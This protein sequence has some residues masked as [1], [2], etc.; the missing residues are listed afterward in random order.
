MSNFVNKAN[1]TD[2]D[3]ARARHETGM[4]RVRERI[5]QIV[6]RLR[7]E[8]KKQEIQEALQDGRDPIVSEIL[9]ARGAQ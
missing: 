8:K 2:A 9:A 6:S 3:R 7:H 1:M 5:D 4:A